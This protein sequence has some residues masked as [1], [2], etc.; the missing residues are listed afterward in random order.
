[1]IRAKFKVQSVTTFEGGHESVDLYAVH[2]K[3]NEGWAKATPGGNLKLN[4]SNPD[5]IGKLKIGQ[6]YYLDFSEAP[7]KEEDEK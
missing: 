3:G 6:C 4:I 1:M 5:A 2:G 7:A